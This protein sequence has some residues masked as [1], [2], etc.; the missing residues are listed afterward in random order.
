WTKVK[1]V[2]KAGFINFW[3]NGWVS[4]ATVLVVII[5]LFS[6]GSLIFAKAILS[7]TLAQIQ[8]KVD[9]SVYFKTDADEQDI[10]ALKSKLEKTGEVKSVEY[11]SSE[12]ALEN[13]KERHKDNALIMQSLEELESNPLGAVLNVKAKETSQYESIAKS[14]EISSGLSAETSIIDKINYYQN[15]V[16][17]DR[18]TK[19][20]DSTKRLGI[21]ISIILI[22]ISLL[23]TFNTVRLAIYSSREEIGIM[24]LVGASGKFI[25]GPFVIEGI[26]HGIIASI[27]TMALFYPCTLWLGKM[28]QNFFGGINIFE[29]Y[30]SNFVQLFLII[31]GTGIILG[32]IS[33]FIAVRRYLKV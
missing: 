8:D 5:T 17:I 24:R 2:I 18:L 10:L 12:Q 3:R 31:L 33:S 9:V 20:L 14:L 26:M 16:V 13:F 7:S 30:I 29:Y 23:V 11:I 15:R 19:I 25:S 32:A 4:L 22:I 27:V 1:R 28:T 21:I 6:I